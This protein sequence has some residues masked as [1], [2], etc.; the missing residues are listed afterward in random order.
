MVAAL[1]AVLSTPLRA[2]AGPLSR[3]RPGDP[4]WPTPARWQ[5]LKDQVGDALVPV[6]SPLL[7]C[8]TSHDEAACALLF[9]SLKNPYFL[10][11]E[12]GLTQTLGWVDAWTSRPSVYAV[13]ARNTRDVVAAVNFAREH[14]LRLVVK[15]GGH[16]YQGTSNAPDS[17]LVWTRRMNDITLHDAFI[18]SGCERRASPTRAVTVGAGAIWAQVY[19]AV[20]TRGGGYVQGGGCTTVGVAGLV[21]GGGFGSFSKAFGLAAASLL[22]AE[23]VTADGV[24]RVCNACTNADLF[25]ALK[26]GGGGSLGVV[27][28]LTLKVHE[29]PETFGA[30]NFSV[31]ATSDAAFTK[32]V[33]MA[34]DL[35]ASSLMN[36]HWGEQIRL[37]GNMLQVAM[38]FQGLTRA[39]AGAVWRPFFDAL[40]KAPDDYKLD[41][42]P[43]KIVSTSARE[44]WSP[45]LLKRVFG[46]IRRDDR[47]GAPQ[48]NVFWPGDEGQAAQV[49]HGYGSTWLPATLLQ[50]AQR[51]ALVGALVAASRHWGLGVHFNK[52]LA[53]ASPEVIAAA[54]DTPVNPAV[55]DAFALVISGAGEQPAYP[56]VAG[57]EPN[58]ALARQRRQ[59]VAQTM[60][61]LRKLVPNAGSYLSESDYFEADWQRSHWGANYARLAAV[62]A[63]VDPDDLF[64]VHHGVGSERWSDDGFTRKAMDQG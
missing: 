44:F 3:T 1:A 21:Q 50:P 60:A 30:V 11:D 12:V 28:R 32:L 55:L 53:G 35:Y 2:A 20:T 61:E 29:L 7:A 24:V 52:G 63:M 38:V 31:R 23:V 14:N 27:T 49:L 39:E 22:Q 25:W 41:F 5:Q 48:T 37:R 58:A 40:D 33:A 26:G 43:L 15:G 51:P 17:L 36:A 10:G 16:S 47:P 9:K 19:D 13:A 64:I 54:R 45:T 42:S 8:T 59:A 18:A 57:H 6:R 34:V 46:F 56:G 62:K 4:G